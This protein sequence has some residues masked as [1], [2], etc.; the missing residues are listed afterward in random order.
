MDKKNNLGISVELSMYPLS[1]EYKPLIVNFVE[2][3]QQKEG[4]TVLMN[5]M[6]TRIFGAYDV[7][8]PMLTEELRISFETP[9]A[10][11]VVMKLV[12][13]NLEE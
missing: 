10:I 2:R 4:V 5:N 6:S 7:V 1:E 13:R 3:I 11:V 8:L 9:N 12:N